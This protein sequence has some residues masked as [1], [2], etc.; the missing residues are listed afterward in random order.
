MNLITLAVF[1]A[2]GCVCFF[3]FVHAREAEKF[4]KII[5]RTFLVSVNLQQYVDDKG[6]FP[7]SLTNLVAENQL[8]SRLLLPL[9]NETTSYRPPDKLTNSSWKLIVV[10]YK[11]RKIV[12][13]KNFEKEITK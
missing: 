5:D 4:A 2:I 8:D 3:W 10:K 1:I 7:G 9:D 11:N 6:H 13:F 12:I